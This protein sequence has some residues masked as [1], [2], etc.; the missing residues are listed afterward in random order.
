MAK[1]NW[2]TYFWFSLHFIYICDEDCYI[3]SRL[4]WFS[5]NN[6]VSKRFSCVNWF[7]GAYLKK[8]AKNKSQKNIQHPS[9][10][11]GFL[12]HSFKWACQFGCF[13]QHTPWLEVLACSLDTDLNYVPAMLQLH[14]SLNHYI[15]LWQHLGGRWGNFLS[16]LS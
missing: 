4:L 2:L 6:V 8:V 5:F 14:P 15:K 7:C 9:R 3:F 11:S 13:L 1:L 16:V 10:M 12:W